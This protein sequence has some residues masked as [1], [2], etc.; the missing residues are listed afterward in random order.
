MIL[1]ILFF[2]S[3][4]FLPKKIN[5]YVEAS[6]YLESM[7]VNIKTEAYTS[8]ST[9]SKRVMVIPEGV[10][11]DRIEKKTSW[12][13]VRYNGKTGWV[14]SRNLV[15]ITKIEVL[16]TKQTVTM[17]ASRSTKGKVITKIP[18]NKQV[19]RL[20]V[21]KSWSNVQYGS[22]KGWVATSKLNLRYTKETFAP[23]QYKLKETASL[24]S[25]YTSS[26]KKII[27]IPKGSIVKSAEKYNQWFKVTYNNKTGW[28]QAKYLQS[29]KS[30]LKVAQS[31]Y[32][33]NYIITSHNGDL[34]ITDEILHTVALFD[35]GLI[36]EYG[37][38]E[39]YNKAAKLITTL[40]GGSS[41]E[42]SEYMWSALWGY[43]YTYGK[44]R[45]SPSSSSYETVVVFW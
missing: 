28:I 43:S 21:N 34:M 2:P 44:Y 9:K 4:E 40:H 6:I 1:T 17:Y 3:S 7:Y 26:G 18:I 19:S 20:E 45:I 11:V 39:E 31:I 37:T 5:N 25:T 41:S 24:Q 16:D 10:P 32:G 29:Y 13:L 38:R 12:S 15:A 36:I 23:R 33:S 42:L 22:K 30:P 35:D 14:P 27:S 8:R